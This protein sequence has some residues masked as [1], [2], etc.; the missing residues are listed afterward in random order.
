MTIK[1][2][3]IKNM[4]KFTVPAE[5]KGWQELRFAMN[6]YSRAVRE[7]ASTAHNVLDFLGAPKT[8]PFVGIDDEGRV[9]AEDLETGEKEY[10]DD[11]YFMSTQE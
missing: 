4:A 2:K 10:P 3:H 11:E 1:V 6:D 7:F 8:E 9:Y 5:T